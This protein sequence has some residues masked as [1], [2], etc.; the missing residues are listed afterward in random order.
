MLR[1][2]DKL[3]HGQGIRSDSGHIK[4]SRHK[5]TKAVTKQS[6]I[7]GT[8]KPYFTSETCSAFST[9]WLMG[10]AS[11]LIPAISRAHATRSQK[12]SQNK[13]A[14]AARQN[15]IS[16]RRHAPLFR[17]AGSWARHRNE[18]RVLAP[19]SIVRD[20]P[21]A[22]LAGLAAGQGLM[23]DCQER[24]FTRRTRYL[25]DWVQVGNQTEN[26]AAHPPRAA[27]F[28]SAALRHGMVQPTR[29]RTE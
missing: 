22:A 15:L 25:F 9:S 27:D 1:F 4:G 18:S 12:Q 26:V 3:A 10:K 24:G 29:V 21:L 16:R 5:V 19:P 17:Q 11:D 23:L 7:S 14:L 13:A 2:F 8:A 6:G 20:G 28:L